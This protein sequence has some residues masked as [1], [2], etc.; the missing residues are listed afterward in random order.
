[1]FDLA[2]PTDSEMEKHWIVKAFRMEQQS[3]I[4]WERKS[5][6]DSLLEIPMVQR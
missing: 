5:E 3:V 1:M 4:S 6:L 2:L